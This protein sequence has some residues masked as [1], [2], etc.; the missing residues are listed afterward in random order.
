M[1]PRSPQ[2][3]LAD[4]LVAIRAIRS[5]E[6]TGQEHGLDRGDL[7]VPDAVV[8]QLAVIGE[9]VSVMPDE[10]V[11]RRPDIP[12]KD[13][14]GM[15]RL[16]DHQYHRVDAAVVWNTVDDHLAVLEEAVEELLDR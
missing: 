1:T 15:R 13:I 11:G 10:V 12:W 14:A 3:R 2:Q 8:R 4:V 6:V 9:A 7:L 5:H 16:L